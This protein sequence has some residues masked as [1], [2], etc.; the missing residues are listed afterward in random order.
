MYFIDKKVRENAFPTSVSLAADYKAK[1]GVP[2]DPRTIAADIAVLKEKFKA[3]LKYDYQNRGY[4]YSDPNFRLPVLQEDPDNP[5]PSLAEE[6]HP[7]TAAIPEWQQKLIVSLLDK[8]RLPSEEKIPRYGKI[9]ILENKPDLWEAGTETVKKPLLRALEDG[10]VLKIRYM[11]AGRKAAAFEFQPLHLICTLGFNLIFGICQTGVEPQYRLLYLDRVAE[12][13]PRQKKTRQPSYVYIQ[14][15]G[16]C[17]IEAVIA[18]E[19]SDM[20]LVFAPLREG[21]SEGKPPEYGLLAKA[22]IF[23]L[24]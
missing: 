12:A 21:Q 5:L 17:D 24:R 4:R 14:S 1:Y 23:A 11:E 22:E 18:G 9:S 15:S 13:A 16:E 6:K 8:T 2:V 3:P 19:Y 10:A 20:L 7:R